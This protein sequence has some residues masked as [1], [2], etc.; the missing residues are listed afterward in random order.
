HIV[1]H[2][3]GGAIA[4][5]FAAFHPELTERLAILNCPHPL[6]LMR[7]FRTAKQ[8]QKSWYMFFFQLPRIPER[9]LAENDYAYVR[10][11]FRSD[12]VP[13]S[14]IEPYVDA[15]RVPGAATAAINY[16]RASLRRVLTGDVPKTLG[17]EAPVLVLWGDADKY[18]GAEMAAP[19]ARFVPNARVVFIP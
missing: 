17:V 1:G 18:L 4:W 2:D 15:M 19:P 6:N 16:Y 3:W 14:E 11:T 5:A 10:R 12:G 13:A 7:A 9:K 8:L